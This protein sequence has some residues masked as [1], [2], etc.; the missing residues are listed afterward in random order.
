MTQLSTFVSVALCEAFVFAAVLAVGGLVGWVK[1]GSRMSA[2]MGVLT[3]LIV[4]VSAF[5]ADSN[6]WPSSMLILSLTALTLTV[7]FFE[8]YINSSRKFM[9]GGFM[10]MI[11]GISFFLYVSTLVFG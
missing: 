4:S 6:S 9:P 2:V 1:R 11:C 7:F 10:S 3:A 5:Y 8:R